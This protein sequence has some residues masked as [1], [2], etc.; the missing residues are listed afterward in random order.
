MTS[1]PP[2]PALP[3]DARLEIFVYP[4]GISQNRPLEEGNRFSDCHRLQYLG[5]IMVSAAYHD[6]MAQR[7]PSASAEQLKGMVETTLDGFME[8]HAAAY[9]WSDMV[10]GYPAGFDQNSLEEARRLFCTYAGAVHVEHGYERLK[11]WIVAL[12]GV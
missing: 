8:T 9:R 1:V 2:A 4:F 6:A 12:L 7:W 10:L 11:E 3:G 5:R